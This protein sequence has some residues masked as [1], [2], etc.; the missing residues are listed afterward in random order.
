MTALPEA[1]LAREAEMCYATDAMVSDFDCWKENE[2]VVT[3]EM[4]VENLTKN[5]ETSRNIVSK[6]S[7]EY[8]LNNS[9]E[10][11]NS[12]EHSIITDLRKVDQSRLESIRLL[13]DKY[14]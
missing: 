8:Q 14:M 4:I 10:C 1:K 13:I 9:C 2:S 11:R 5:V 3:A 6:M 12:L 7:T